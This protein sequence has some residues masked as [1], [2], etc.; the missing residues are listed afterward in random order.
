MPKEITVELRLET[1]VRTICDGILAGA[2]HKNHGLY[3]G[4]DLR[5]DTDP[6]YYEQRSVAVGVHLLRFWDR[7]LGA[8]DDKFIFMR[9]NP[10]CDWE[11]ISQHDSCWA[12]STDHWVNDIVRDVMTNGDKSKYTQ[13]YK[14]DG[15]I[16][17]EQHAHRTH[18]MMSGVQLVDIEQLRGVSFTD[19][20]SD[21][22]GKKPLIRPGVC[23]S[24]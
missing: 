12:D 21:Y 1:T 23:L 5:I 2:M 10:I 6:R 19:P 11:Q 8:T 16:Y 4:F 18:L 24:A 20:H 22:K 7:I 3:L 15:L 17:G 14:E 13:R 9:F